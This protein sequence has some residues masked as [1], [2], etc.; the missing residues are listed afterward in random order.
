MD[1]TETEPDNQ[2]IARTANSTPDDIPGGVEGDL[3][4]FLPL[5]PTP[6]EGVPIFTVERFREQ[7]KHRVK[8][9]LGQ[10]W[11]TNISTKNL[12]WV[13]ALA[14]RDLM[15]ERYLSTQRRYKRSGA[16]RVYYL[17]MEFLMGSS[18][19][20][21]LNNLGIEYQAEQIV[22]EFGHTLD[23]LYEEEVDA[24][25]GNGG[26]GRLAA[27][28]LD[29]MATMN[30]P[31]FGYG[32]NYEY[33]LFRQRIENG[34][35]VEMP[36]SWR[37]LN[38]PWLLDRQ[39]EQ[40]VIPIYGRV[41]EAPDRLGNIKPAWVDVRSFIGVPSDMPVVGFG[42][43]TV[44]Y[45]R[46]YSA[47]AFEEFDI[48]K[49]NQGEYVKA[50]E[51][52]IAS[53]TVSKVLYPSDAVES[54]REL[55]L[56]QEY[57]FVACA[58]RDII[59]RYLK[60][61]AT[62]DD[63][64]N[65]V[66]IQLNDTHPALAVA[67]LMRIL[68]DENHVEWDNAWDITVATLGYTNHTLLPEALEK[69]PVEL[70]E[71]VLPRHLRIIYDINEMF[72]DQVAQLW[73]DDTERLQRMSIVEEGPG[74]KEIRMAHLAIVG[75]HAINGVANLHTELVK[76][77]L[78]PEFY[79]MWPERF[80]NKTNGVTQR[81]WLMKSNPK[82]A[83]LLTDCV[84]E[85]WVCDLNHLRNLESHVNDSATQESFDQIKRDNK[86]RLAGIIRETTGTI[87][88]PD[89]IFDVIAKRIHEYKRQLLMVMRVIHDYLAVIEDGVIPEHSQTYIF[90][91]KAAPGYWAAKQI[92]QLV[93]DLADIINNDFRVR[94][95]IKVVFIPDY[96]VSLAERIMPAAN[97][98]EQI[99]TAGKEASGTGN[100]KFAMNG[101]LT[102]G[103]LDGANIEIRDAVGPEN[104]FL[105]GLR[106]DQIHKMR[107]TDSYSP[108]D[109]Y[110][111]SE[112]IRRVMDVFN[113]DT[114][115]PRG[116]GAYRWI[117]NSILHHGDPYFH[118]ADLESY[119]QAQTQAVTEYM[120]KPLWTRKC[121]I[122][123][124]RMG[125]F[126]SDRTIAEYARDIWHIKP[127]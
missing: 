86:V 95:R 9:S 38:S 49:F 17:S 16:K 45:L 106:A 109:Y 123:I 110:R 57:F 15:M 64:P 76:S 94:D 78:V 91:G 54:G 67:E 10:D 90:A 92:I 32:I 13:V 30:L 79:E 1:F 99:S 81:R 60:R 116:P 115:F 40:V 101:A 34:Q 39:D 53:E 104:F 63:F 26:L 89:S 12:L 107:E 112:P 31:G 88:D 27:C 87:V 84:G 70:F 35:Q 47:R 126:S 103:T 55:R 18:L 125:H 46:L 19:A 43:R 69:W 97:I 113:S 33:G 82:L 72:L 74:F 121:L 111:R 102:V 119:L 105:F 80:S 44:N 29:S 23:E 41:V 93:N 62:F 11:G 124:A 5:N 68:V 7:L 65:Q 36:D 50:V 21:N 85:R 59:R 66:A 56:V 4:T 108:W 118:L 42:G 73:P 51:Q 100:M 117:F 52:R 37:P 2:P 3:D 71:R 127:V 24:A 58:I 83:K 122:N 20:N 48:Q 8:Y 114:F 61:N 75:S 96:R 98:S 28:F 14:V 77:Q 25:L 22:R 6:L 120:D